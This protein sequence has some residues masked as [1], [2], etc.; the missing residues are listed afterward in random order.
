MASADLGICLHASSSGFDL[1]MK[2]VDMFSA[3][4]PCL[5]IGG[6]PSLCELV[7]DNVNGKSFWTSEQLAEQII[8][9]LSG[10]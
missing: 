5:A 2:V 10:Y 6:Y 4:L 3:E 7:Q 1:P 9:V 8:E